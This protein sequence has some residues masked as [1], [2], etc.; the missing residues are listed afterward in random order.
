MDAAASANNQQRRTSK[1]VGPS[2]LGQDIAINGSVSAEGE[3]QLDGAVDGD[4][5]AG[6]LTIG[7]QAVVKGEIEAES[8]VVRGQVSG[9][10]KARHVQLAATSRVEGDILHTS[11]AIE[12]GAYFEG[13]CRRADAQKSAPKPAGAESKPANGSG[14]AANQSSSSGQQPGGQA[15]KTG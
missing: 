8:V 15:V 1:N 11:L 5:R 13:H 6:S 7:E 14:T 10:I 12:S 2:I 9:S 4:V 3:I